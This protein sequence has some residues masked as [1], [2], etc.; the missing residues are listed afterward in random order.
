MSTASEGLQLAGDLFVVIILL[1]IAFICGRMSNR[2]G[3][4][5]NAVINQNTIE[6]LEAD[7]STL[8]ASKH[9]GASVRQY[10]NKYRR[11][12][13]VEIITGKSFA[14]HQ[15][16]L[17]IDAM[18]STDSI[19]DKDNIYFVDNK[20]EYFCEADRDSNGYYKTIRFI[21]VG[22][23]NEVL[24]EVPITG[25]D[26]AKS[27]LIAALGGDSSMTWEEI[28]NAAKFTTESSKNAKSKIVTELGK[29]AVHDIVT[30][31][32]AWDDVSNAVGDT[33]KSLHDTADGA[34]NQSGHTRVAFSLSGDDE[35]LR[36]KTLEFTP[37]VVIVIDDATGKKYMWTSEGGTGWFESPACV[38][39]SNRTI[40]YNLASGSVSIIAY[41]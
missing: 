14:T 10:V 25:A 7:V 39:V 31:D 27:H 4:A 1:T 33:L 8:L 28:V 15:S 38:S 34:I 18:T 24:S 32:S 40:S 41:K 22:A 20:A 9:T 12:M 13:G 19:R 23:R 21:Q 16:P 35:L 2:M 29:Y 26:S 6:Y 5:S 11:K 17:K 37:S 30:T 36:S 3:Q